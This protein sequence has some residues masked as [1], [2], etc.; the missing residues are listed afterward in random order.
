M[1]VILITGANRGIGLEFVRQYAREGDHI[2]ACCRSPE[3]AYD[4]QP[5]FDSVEIQQLDISRSESIQQ[6]VNKL[7]GI[8]IDLLINNAAIFGGSNSKLDTLD[9]G[10]WIVTLQT[11]TIGPLVLT[12]ALLD[13]LTLSSNGKVMFLSSRAGCTNEIKQSGSIIYRASKAALNSAIRSASFDLAKHGIACAALNPGFV[14]TGFGGPNAP[15]TATES[16]KALRSVIARVTLENTGLLW[17]F[18]GAVLNF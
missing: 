5:A 7:A 17:H 6:L 10:R 13:N 12:R 15:M 4:L 16:V 9:A 8:K 18:D 14:Q 11:N 2:I 1:P 3:T